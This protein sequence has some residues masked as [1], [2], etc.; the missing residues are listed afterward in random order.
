VRYTYDNNYFNDRH[1]GLPV[2]GYTAWFERMLDNPRIDVRLETD[3]LADSGPFSKGAVVGSL[4]VVYTGPIDKYFDYS[5]GALSWRTVD[6]QTEVLPVPDFQGTSVMNYADLDT[7]FTR[8]IEPRHFY[9]ERAYPDSATVIMREF[10]RSAQLSDEP[11]YPV[12][13]ESDRTRLSAYKVRAAA[14]PDILFGGRLGSYQYF[15]MHVTVA[16]A[17]AAFEQ[18]VKPRFA[19]KR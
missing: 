12:N 8:I 19:K 3:F 13:T 9:P 16:A 2:D 7:P 6:F 14:E 11:Y 5:E 1:Q 15:D 17:L 4:P 18:W 10:S